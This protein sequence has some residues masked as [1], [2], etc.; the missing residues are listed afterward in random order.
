MKKIVRAVQS[1]SLFLQTNFFFLSFARKMWRHR[2]QIH[3]FQLERW[4]FDDFLEDH[5]ALLV[6][7]DSNCERIGEGFS[8][9]KEGESSSSFTWTPCVLEQMFCQHSLYHS[10]NTRS[11]VDPTDP[12]TVA[13]HANKQQP[14]NVQ[15]QACVIFSVCSFGNFQWP[16]LMNK[17]WVKTK[18]KNE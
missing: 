6:K 9:K 2:S 16:F 5:L 12:T 18:K 10:H 17:K 1:F 13:A 4:E 7:V 11:T 14:N 15:Q 8:E 3:W